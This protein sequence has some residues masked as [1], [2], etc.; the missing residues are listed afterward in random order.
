VSVYADFR[1]DK[2]PRKANRKN[3]IPVKNLR[4]SGNVYQGSVTVPA[5]GCY[6]LWAD[7]APQHIKSTRV[8]ASF[9]KICND[10]RARFSTIRPGLGLLYTGSYTGWYF[11]LEK[12]TF[13]F[14]FKGL[15]PKHKVNHFFIT[16]H[17][18]EILR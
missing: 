5:K 13:S 3:L 4:R 12:G 6:F 2:T 11:F 8:T 1:N 17:P 16:A 7:V 9:G 14:T 18:E 10:S 15:D